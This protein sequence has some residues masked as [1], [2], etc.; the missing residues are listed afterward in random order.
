M[1]GVLLGHHAGGLKGAVGDLSHAE[2]LV[3]SLLC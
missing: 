3:V 1:G 2:L